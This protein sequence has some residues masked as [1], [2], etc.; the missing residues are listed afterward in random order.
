MLLH[1]SELPSFL[2]L[3]NFNVTVLKIKKTGSILLILPF[4]SAHN[5]TDPVFTIYNFGI[6]FIMYIFVFILIF[7]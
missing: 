6:F 5:V 1:V 4:V 7:F 3:D 2:S